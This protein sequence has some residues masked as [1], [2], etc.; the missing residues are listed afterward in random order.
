MLVKLRNEIKQTG[1]LSPAFTRLKET[2]WHN[3][4]PGPGQREITATLSCRSSAHSW[5]KEYT[6][7]DRTHVRGLTAN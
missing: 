4:R 1:S 3:I 6:E 2:R 7:H 5:W